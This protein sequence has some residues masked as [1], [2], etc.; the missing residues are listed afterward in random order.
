MKQQTRMALFSII[1]PLIAAL[2]M[3]MIVFNN[4]FSSSK[5]SSR[6][7]LGGGQYTVAQQQAPQHV[8]AQQQAPRANNYTRRDIIPQ[9][10]RTRWNPCET[11]ANC[12]SGTECRNTARNGQTP[13]KR[14]L[15]KGDAEYVCM[16]AGNR[17]YINNKCV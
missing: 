16:Q 8:Q 7:N 3:T 14:C 6:R 13:F 9:G 10:S 15:S 12:V 4:P 2:L 1:G 5:E 11:S 17:R